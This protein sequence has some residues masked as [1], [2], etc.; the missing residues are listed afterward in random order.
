[1]LHK[2]HPHSCKIHAFLSVFLAFHGKTAS[3][4]IYYKMKTT[5]TFEN[6]YRARA[7]VLQSKKALTRYI[8]R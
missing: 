5:F 3:F 7:L 2:S 6:F 4:L 8:Y 1:M